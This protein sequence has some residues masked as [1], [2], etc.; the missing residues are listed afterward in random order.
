[1]FAGTVVTF[2]ASGVS[3]AQP[4]YFQ[5]Q[6]NNGG[7]FANV[8]GANTNTLV[9][10][11]GITNTGSF[12]LVV[13]NSYGAA[14]SAPVSLTVTATTINQLTVSPA[15]NV[16]VG[17]PVTFAASVSGA[18]P[19][20]FQWQFNN[21]GGFINV[22]GANTNTLAFNAAV[23]N[24]GSYQ[25]VVT[26]NYG[27]TTSAPVALSVTLDTN[28][29]LV[30]NCFN[31]NTTN[32][33]LDF[34]KVLEA[35]S[36]TNPANYVFTNGLAITAASLAPN[37]LSVILTT[38]P[39][40]YGGNY[41]LIINGVRDQSVPPNTIATNTLVNFTASPRERVLIDSA[42]R[43]QLGD[44]GDVT[45]NVTVYLEISNLAKLAAADVDAETA[46][47]ASR[48][49][50]VA[51]HAGEDISFVMT[52]Y[53]DSS[54]RM[55]DLPHD[56][57]VELPFDSG[58]NISHG[59]KAKSGTN[60]IGWYRRTFTLPAG[61]AGKNM[62]LDFDGT[63][64]NALIWL[65]GHCIGRNVSGYAPNHFDITPYANPGG[66]NVLVVRV[67]ATRDEGWFYE[68]GGI[69]RHV[70]LVKTAP[71]HV[72]HW[73]TFVA[74]TS[75]AGSN[76]TITIQTDVTNQSGSTATGSLT[77]TIL[78]A[79]N[80]AV[81]NITSAISVLSGQHVVVTQV[82]AMA[83]N[84]WSLESPYLY[85]LVSTVTNQSAK[86]DVYTT[87]FGVRT[88]SFDGING[89][90]INGKH[91][92][93]QGQCNHQD[94]AG[95]GSAIPDRL[96]YFRIEKLKQM[97]VNAYRT[98][99]N[100]PTAEMLEACDRLGM[101]VM[102][103]TRRFG[104]DSESLGQLERIMRRDRNHPSVFIWSLA[105]E[106]WDFQATTQGASVIQTMQNLAHSLDPTRKC[107]AA[108]M[109]AYGGSGFDTVIDVAGFNYNLGSL[110]PSYHNS[111]PYI[112]GTELG[113]T[114]TTR[115]IYSN[116]TVR[117]YV[118]SYDIA[119][120]DAN[121]TSSAEDWWS[122]Y[123]GYPWSSGGFNWTGFDYR[124]EP[125][126]YYTGWP[127]IN[128]HFGIMD[129]CGFPKDL[130]YYYQANWSPKTVLHVFPH[131]NW[132]TTGQVIRVWAY[133]N[134]DAVQLFTNN[135][136]L[137]T[138]ALSVLGHVEWN[139]PYVPG[140]LKG[141]GYRN[142]HAVITNTVET[143]GTP[144]KLALWPDR[145][146]I[147]AD[148]R[149]VSVVT[150]AVLDSSNRVVPTATNF[151]TFT[152]A[153]GA[154]IGVGNGDP[155]CHEADKA[156]NQR[157]I[158][159]G[160]AQV[161]VQ[162]LA[163]TGPIV[164]GAT[165]SG[166]ASMNVT[167]TAATTLPVPDAPAGVMTAT[168]DGQV[169]VS[170]DV[171]PGA[172]GYN[173]KRSTSSSGP[174]TII[175]ANTAALGFVDTNVSFLTPYYY[176]VTALNSSGESLN[177]AEVGA[178]SDAFVTATARVVNS[179][180]QLNWN[181]HAGVTGYNVKRSLVTG[182]PYTT[183]ASNLVATTYTDAGAGTCQ[184]YYYIV[185]MTVGSTESSP[186]AEVNAF[187]PYLVWPYQ[188]VDIGTVGIA[189]SATSCGGP[190]TVAGSGDDIWNAADAFQFVYVYL[191]VS[192]NCDIRAKVLS[193]ANTD[194]W[195]KA[196]VM[197][198][199]SLAS[200]SR[201]VYMAISYTNGAT[202]QNRATTGG[203]T[204]SSSTT[205][206]GAPYWVRV[207]RTN[208]IF[209]AFR[210]SDGT[211]WNTVGSATTILMSTNAYV[212]LAVTAHNNAALNASVFTN[213]TVL[214]PSLPINSAPVLN[215]T[216]DVT[217]NVGGT[218]TNTVVALDAELSSQTLTFSLLNGSADS[219][220][221]IS[222][223][224]AAF[225][226]RPKVTD[227]NTTNLIRVKVAD[228]G[229][230]TLSATQS[231]SVK[232]N[233]LP[234]PS[235]SSVTFNNGQLTLLVTNSLI[236]PDYGVLVSSNLINWSMLFTTNQPAMPF[237]W[238]DTNGATSPKLFY[239]I[240]VG[241]PLP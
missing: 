47:Q 91:V 165:A 125:T 133:G 169:T 44:P 20:Y 186:S 170:W 105:N 114:V 155:S 228:S 141:I 70:W 136:S 236:G 176:V 206:I 100:P 110:T 126:P 69:Y 166:L 210:S 23:T 109:G 66:T 24:I 65:N 76:A 89:C 99:H 4:L 18:Q 101:L 164:L 12:R 189:G 179:Q 124:G 1:V 205:G 200:G 10:T 162:S 57:V 67:D 7:G 209:R 54:W 183:I 161:I 223:T 19:L 34:S 172:T 177:S 88:V 227:A 115:G 93:I 64:R 191:P 197:I 40:V 235:V 46:L 94:H 90:L 8:A 217:T 73:G 84:P 39:L 62:W 17:T 51:T 119:S 159:N 129:T 232:V 103:E 127:V 204:T 28:A 38:A 142:G 222:S 71:V 220:T 6:F 32:V 163:Q 173:V 68:G 97:G 108:I 107:T 139:V 16:F 224:N 104:W 122:L 81:T 158:F 138:K 25:L 11:A 135:V 79:G 190:Y 146:T 212:G 27:A 78:D 148:G 187:V 226:W 130:F 153:G 134:C 239:R 121:W 45:T 96:Q 184:I 218:V 95:V 140:T 55:L 211:T 171:T 56:W 192:T 194:P 240:K 80:N 174:Y 150:V 154:I 98:S 157:S 231:F 3:G 137:G 82:V 14:T 149:D 72:A 35:A 102:D 132:S 111:H 37:K 92:E 207:T 145:R 156:S 160:F 21:G 74:T 185:T 215:P 30:L 106:E 117:G 196:G 113:S 86:A 182:G 13:T 15:N 43:F 143:T 60:N 41:T 225:S 63:Y 116:D 198:R 214:S 237:S 221:K 188:G 2:T 83:V 87:P 22:A 230:P 59:L 167:I 178:T 29:P 123:H 53:N 128:S 219:F 147:L 201:N 152:I 31:I 49:D 131:W 33:E 61:D 175:S 9:L 48:P 199:E 180:V 36:A 50:P 52:N 202:F 238:T 195:A 241:P 203:T 229:F 58:G 144:A 118:Q 77:S 151:V 216:S 75:L 193:I 181:A 208:N 85:N 42:W 26:N 213:F 234:V 233:P 120:P 168:G 5:W 112:I